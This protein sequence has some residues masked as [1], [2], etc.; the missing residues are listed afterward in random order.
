MFVA[1][2]DASTPTLRAKARH[3]SNPAE[4]AENTDLDNADTEQAYV[5]LG[6]ANDTPHGGDGDE[7]GSAGP[8]EHIELDAT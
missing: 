7:F 6:F 3:V 8:D 4:L 1:D 5:D 2:E